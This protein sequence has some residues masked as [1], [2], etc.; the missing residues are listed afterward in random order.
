MN[1]SKTSI[2]KTK[3]WLRAIA[4]LVAVVLLPLTTAQAQR[5]NHRAVG[6]R[7]RAAVSAGEL[8][9]EQARAM[10]AVISGQRGSDRRSDSRGRS[11]RSRSGRNRGQRSEQ[12][13]RRTGSRG[14]RRDRG[15]PP[16]ERMHALRKKLVAAVRAGKLSREDAGK[17]MRVAVAQVKKKMA[18]ARKPHANTGRS[19]A[20]GAKKWLQG[21]RKE[22][23]AAVEAGKMSRIDAAKKMKAA[24]TGIKKKLA[25]A[26]K[27]KGKDAG[28][29]KSKGKDARAK[30]PK[31]KEAKSKKSRARKSGARKSRVPK[32]RTS[33]DPKAKKTVADAKTT[34]IGERG[35][36]YLVKV[37]KDV[38]AAVKAGKM[39]RKQAVERIKAATE[40][41]Q[42]RMAGVRKPRRSEPKEDSKRTRNRTRSSAGRRRESD[43][44]P[45]RVKTKDEPRRSRSEDSKDRVRPQSDTVQKSVHGV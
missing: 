19:D 22:I 4:L 42:K 12:R 26:K 10:M 34:D 30:K 15:Q 7:L 25:G 16:Q 32:A 35:R 9:G 41:I 20:A 2:P 1:V 11:E 14:G 36:A 28:A 39:T 6:V 45:G 24:V 23:G 8:S 21:V 17:K 3:I 44:A 40:A 31:G 5:T 29:K 43:R 13:R 37:R 33:K 27:S 18:G 38:G